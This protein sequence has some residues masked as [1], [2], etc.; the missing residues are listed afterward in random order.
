MRKFE[1]EELKAVCCNKCSK[2]LVVEKGIIKEGCYNGDVVWGYFSTM[3][4]I[5][6]NFDL[7]EDC[8]Q[9]MIRAFAIPV[10]VNDETE[11]V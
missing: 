10:E 4:G 7:C 2:P 1:N 5:R 11:F 6:H 9:S 8:Y 3:D